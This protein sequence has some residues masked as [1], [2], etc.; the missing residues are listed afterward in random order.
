M[1]QEQTP[2]RPTESHHPGGRAPD[3][4][5]T[6]LVRQVAAKAT[7]L[8]QKEV[9]L[10]RNEVR[11]DVASELAMAKRLGVA[12]VAGI[13]T[14]NLLLMAAVFALTPYVPGW[15]TALVLAG[16]ALVAAL[17][18]GLLAWRAHVSRPLALTRRTV[19]EDIRWAKEQ[20]A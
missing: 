14:L 6:E 16:V 9:E 17:L 18:A 19:M 13:V 20:M 15:L 2:V 12:A 7:L 3:L 4:S 5:T 10:A 1:T 11:H 8:V